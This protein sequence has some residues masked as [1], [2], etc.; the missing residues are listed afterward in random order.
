MH[1]ICQMK[2][3]IY[4]IKWL[5]GYLIYSTYLTEIRWKSW[6]TKSESPCSIKV[7]RTPR[8][9]LSNIY[10]RPCLKSLSEESEEHGEVDGARGLIH[11]GLEVVVGG[12]F[13][14]GREHVVQVLLVDKP[15]A[16]L[17]NLEKEALP[18][19][20]I[21]QSNLWIFVHKFPLRTILKA[22]LNS[23][24]WS[25]LNM[26]KTLEVALCALFFVVPRRVAVFR[27]DICKKI[28]C[29]CDG[30]T[31]YLLEITWR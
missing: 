26:A 18:F 17:V 2:S 4:M 25:W 27:D 29:V 1:S 9:S 28:T 15:V 22:S 13:T 16:V 31:N 10:N 20:P 3:P 12:V 19:S 30:W 14:Q 5:K 6:H 24:I 8:I 21:H 23:A 11:H 7:V